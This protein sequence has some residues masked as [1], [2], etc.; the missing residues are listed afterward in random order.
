[1]KKRNKILAILLTAGIAYGVY[2][3][4]QL[5]IFVPARIQTEMPLQNAF[6]AN[7]TECFSGSNAVPFLDQKRFRMLTWNIHKGADAGW[8]PDLARF[9]QGQDIVL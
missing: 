5:Q 2:A 6:K 7:G 4:S 9:S 1:M 3:F 8:Q